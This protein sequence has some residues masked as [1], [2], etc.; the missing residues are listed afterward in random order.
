MLYLKN[1]VILLTD[2]L[3]NCIDQCKSSYGF[4]L[5]F[6][7]R[8][9]SFTWEASLKYTGVELDFITTITSEYYL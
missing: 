7:Y 6:S 4:D 3:P 5:L 1:D 2:V 8:T 9:P